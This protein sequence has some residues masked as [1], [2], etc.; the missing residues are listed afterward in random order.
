MFRLQQAVDDYLKENSS[1]PSSQKKLTSNTS[2]RRTSSNATKEIINGLH[3]LSK[4]PTGKLTKKELEAAEIADQALDSYFLRYARKNPLKYIKIIGHLM[5]FV[6]L[7]AMLTPAIAMGIQWVTA[8]CDDAPVLSILELLRL[9][10][11]YLI[12]TSDTLV[13]SHCIIRNNKN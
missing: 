3:D 4:A 11:S 10:I 13:T 1:T 8:L 5:V 2:R 12:G 7:I 6:E 9:G